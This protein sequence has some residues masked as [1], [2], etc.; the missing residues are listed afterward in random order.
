[1][2]LLVFDLMDTVIVDPFYREVPVYLGTSLEELI[3]VKHPTS[4]I[5]FET[6]LTDEMSFLTRFYREDTGLKLAC[7]EEFKQIFFSAY[8]FVDG[9]ETL[10][11]TLRANDQKLW[12]LSN[13]SNWVLQARALLQLD[14]FFEGYCVSC[15]TGHRK[16]SPGAYRALMASTGAAQHLLIDDRPANVEGALQAGMDAIL[17][18]DTD[19][20]RRQLHSRGILEGQMTA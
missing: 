19:A 17:F 20:L 2:P 9:I 6:G 12:V 7:P 4:W 10:L 14:R 5:E 11:A 16:P 8:R 1:M 13:Y 3:Q 15:D 18:T